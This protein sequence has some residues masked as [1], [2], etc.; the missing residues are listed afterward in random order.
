MID[1]T[2]RWTLNNLR[3]LAAPADYDRI[4]GVLEKGIEEY[5]GAVNCR[6]FLTPW[7]WG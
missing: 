5:S 4:K 1:W 2:H 3:N 7:S 6:Y